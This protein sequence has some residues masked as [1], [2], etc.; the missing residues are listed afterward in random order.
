ME[1]IHSKKPTRRVISE[2]N[3][4]RQEQYQD[5]ET[6][7]MAFDTQKVKGQGSTQISHTV[8]WMYQDAETKLMA[9]DTQKVHG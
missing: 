3:S 9:F 5:A 8:T 7:P 6:K 2:I 4:N 1:D